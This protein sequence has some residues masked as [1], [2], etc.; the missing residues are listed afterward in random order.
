MP[1]DIKM[2][3]FSNFVE[4]EGIARMVILI[5]F[6]TTIGCFSYTWGYYEVGH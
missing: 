6:F 5:L 3:S 1:H 4:Q 2:G